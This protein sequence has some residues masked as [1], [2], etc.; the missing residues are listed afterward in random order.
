MKKYLRNIYYLLKKTTSVNATLSNSSPLLNYINPADL[1]PL[2][3]LLRLGTNYGGWIIPSNSLLNGDSICYLAGAGED[4]SFDCEL[5]QRFGCK[6]RIIDP[7]P[8][9]IEHFRQLSDSVLNWKRFPVNNS[10][11][12]FYTLTREHLD[13]L[14]F[15]AKGIADRDTEMKFFFPKNP[16]HIS[17]STV[18]I[19]KTADFF[20]A[21][22]LRLSTMMKL[23]GD[24]NV[25]LLKLDIEGGEYAVIK[26]MMTLGVLPRILLVEF[27]EIHTPLDGDASLRI[28]KS[29]DLLKEAGMRCVCVEGSNATFVSPVLRH[30]LCDR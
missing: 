30:D 13:H 6:V 16:D 12:N 27:D 3:K 21:D 10:N 7:T 8:R 18:N 15:L 2:E 17:C 11:T 9:A 4:I 23:L 28:K 26:D 1:L 5:V 19:Q 20:K 22:C 14:T 25:D 29:F 24:K